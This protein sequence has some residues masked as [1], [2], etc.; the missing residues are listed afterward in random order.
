MR[1]RPAKGIAWAVYDLEW[2][3]TSLEVLLAGAR[4]ADGYR[5][6]A[7]VGALLEWATRPEYA[8]RWL[9]AH[10]GGSYDV[11]FLIVHIV[12]KTDWRAE[13]CYSGSAAVSVTVWREGRKYHFGDSFMLLKG[14]LAKIGEI[15]GLPKFDMASALAGTRA[16]LERYNER[17]C[18]IV[19]LALHRLS[20]DLEALGGALRPTLPSCA[21]ALLRARFLGETLRTSKSA[22]ALGREAYYASRVDVIRDSCESAIY[23][24]RNSSFPASA[25][26]GPLPGAVRRVSSRWD[27]SEL[28]LVECTVSVPASEQLPPLPYRHDGAI[29]HPTGSWSGWYCGTDLHWLEECGGTV[30]RVRKAIHFEPWDDFGHMM[31][32]LYQ[33]RLERRAA[34]DPVGDYSAKILLNGAYGKLGESPEKERALVRPEKLPRDAW[35]IA[36]AVWGVDETAELE[37][38]HVP[39]AVTI[40]ARSR[41]ALGRAMRREGAHRVYYC[42]TDAFIVD[43][44][45]GS[46]ELGEALGQWKVEARIR[47]GVF[48]AP[49]LYALETDSGEKKVRG[50]GFP[51]LDWAAFCRLQSGEK[52]RFETFSRVRTVLATGKVA[53]GVAWKGAPLEGRPKRC[54]IGGGYTRPW[55]VDELA[56]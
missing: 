23:V 42:D 32:A 43:E 47:N 15:I 54:P 6:F 25:I 38:E 56:S 41:V 20:A 49:K 12:D 39:A 26:E 17:D 52:A 14:K 45:T 46:V 53:N 13:V 18:E 5:A 48:L 27:G 51:R 37:H 24:D 33:Y 21:I 29:Y 28:A 9:F 19:W 16:E 10:A 8:D 22:N 50:K 7:S 44:L 40:T 34:G 3:P 2:D 36:H 4:D 11:A 1:P 35:P 31:R 30:E 55:S